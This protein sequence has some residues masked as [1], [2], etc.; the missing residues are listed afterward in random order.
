MKLYRII[1]A[2]LLVSC[3][4]FIFVL[5]S[6]NAEESSS[7]SGSTI[8]FLLNM[9]YPNFKELSQQ[10]AE[11]LI[12]GFQF[13]ARKCAHLTI[14]AVLGIT[15]MLNAL[16]INKI[17]LIY[18]SI[19]SFIFCVVYAISDEIHQMFVTGRSGEVRDV[20]ID[21]CG[22]LIGVVFLTVIAWVFINKKHLNQ[23]KK[24]Y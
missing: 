10:R 12:S 19:I 11:E 7:I 9:F 15:A 24:E 18:R 3:M 20:L 1:S 13:F 21:S 22:S 8:E 17:K 2:F 16:S 14:Y 6:Q 23:N 4:T 5:S